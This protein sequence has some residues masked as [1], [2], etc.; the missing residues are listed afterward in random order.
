MP[1]KSNFDFH[2]NNIKELKR[3]NDHLMTLE[4]FPKKNP[5]YY[6]SREDESGW[7]MATK[8]IIIRKYI[9]AYLNILSRDKK[10]DLFFIDLMSSWGMNRVT[11]SEGK[12][13]F[14]FPG[15]SI[16]ALL[17]SNRARKGFNELYIN[18]YNP[19]CRKVLKKR[20][21]IINIDSKKKSGTKIDT[22]NDQI[23][24]NSWVISLMEEIDD[25]SK[26]KNYLMVVDNEGMNIDFET[27]K[28]IREISEFGDLII[29]FQDVSIGR[30]IS[31]NP[32]NIEKFFGKKISTDT[33]RLEL[34]DI[35]Q[36]Q[37]RSIGFGHI[38]PIKI[39][40]STMFFYTLL[41]CC[42]KPNSAW[43]NMIQ[44]YRDER[45]KN[46]TD[47]DVQTMWNIVTKK[48]MTL[49]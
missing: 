43:L 17:K 38:E 27:I 39:A 3:E 9:G 41:F 48:Q 18:D 6:Y 29:N 14:S 21:D 16:N 15:T 49:F 2:L 26:Y 35:Y 36:D 42:R 20:L 40:T 46:W 1:R 10:R 24:S 22:S 8:Q 23:D 25:I 44:K 32:K 5:E 12:H 13:R 33:K 37:L 11:K 31:K 47:K 28:K 45:F 30:H 7:W 4:G 19:S 34:C